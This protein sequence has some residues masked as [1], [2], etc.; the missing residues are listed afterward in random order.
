MYPKRHR[1]VNQPRFVSSSIGSLADAYPPGT[2]MLWISANVN[3]TC[4]R[5][6]AMSSSVMFLYSVRAGLSSRSSGWNS[7]TQWRQTDQ[8]TKGSRRSGRFR[9]ISR[10]SIFPGQFGERTFSQPAPARHGVEPEPTR[11][12]ARQPSLAE[13]RHQTQDRLHE[14]EDDYESLLEGTGRWQNTDAGA[15]ARGLNAARARLAEARGVVGE[16]AQRVWHQVGEPE[17]R[18]IETDITAATRDLADL[19]REDLTARTA[20]IQA[21]AAVRSTGHGLAL[22]R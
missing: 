6:L 9:Y 1:L 4:R 10:S 22:G 20:R 18:R 8:G 16:N 14:L 17:A 19:G 12:D 2:F 5:T 13:R 21:R 7:I 15:A 11:S 3:L